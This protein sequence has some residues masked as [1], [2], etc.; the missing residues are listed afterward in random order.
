[1]SDILHID[2]LLH[3]SAIVTAVTVGY[4]GLDRIRPAERELE[5]VLE[6]VKESVVIVLNQYGI[7]ATHKRIDN[8]V[9]DIVA[10]YALVYVA[11]FEVRL[12]IHKRIL[13]YIYRSWK[14]PMMGY[15][16]KKIDIRI[17]KV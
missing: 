4:V 15:F 10:V 2:G 12:P 7:T 17:I 1:M 8:F 16:R 14:L 9:F 11:E 5:N 6:K 3:L 13:S